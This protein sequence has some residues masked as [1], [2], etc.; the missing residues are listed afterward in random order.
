MM[1]FLVLFIF[2][3]AD[4]RSI[5]LLGLFTYI[6][7]VVAGDPSATVCEPYGEREGWTWQ[8][9]GGSG[10]RAYFCTGG[11]QESPTFYRGTLFLKTLILSHEFHLLQETAEEG[12]E[13]WTGLMPLK[14][15]AEI[16]GAPR[17]LTEEFKPADH[18]LPGG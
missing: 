4:N 7:S 11:D 8:P 16:A 3:F 2:F 15:T 5:V 1:L 6:S 14:L 9:S 13:E 12:E 10:L 17:I 18:C